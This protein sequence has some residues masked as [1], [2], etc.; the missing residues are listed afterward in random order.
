[1][2]VVQAILG[3]GAIAVVITLIPGLDVTL[4]L[5]TALV[6]GRRHA[7]A[8]ALGICTGAMVWGGA[9]A[10]G[11]AALLAA[12]RAAYMVVTVAGAAY[13]V[14]L[15]ISMLVKSVR[16]GAASHLELT[17]GGAPHAA[18]RAFAT[19]AWT[20][21]LNPKMGVFYVATIPQFIPVGTSHLGMGLLLAGVHVVIAMTWFVVIITG[22]TVARGWLANARALRVIDRIAG[23]VL[24][25]FGA[26][27][28]LQHRW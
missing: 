22:A 1:M 7:L 4:V 21:L 2:T 17:V 6:R 23:V 3:F 24:V 9:A 28:A 12:S 11:A 18:W 15:G 8:A 25:A 14:Y 20:D 19:G 5:R 10:V 27:L 16:L 26:R 13:M